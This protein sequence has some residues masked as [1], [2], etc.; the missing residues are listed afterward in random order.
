SGHGFGADALDGAVVD[1]VAQVSE[2]AHLAF[3][4]PFFVGQI[5]VEEH[6]DAGF[7]VKTGQGDEADPNGH[8]E[9]VVEK[10]EN[11]ERSNQ[12]ERHGHEN[13]GGLHQRTRVEINDEEDDEQGQ[14]HDNHQALLGA[15]HVFVFPAPKD[16]VAAGQMDR[17]F[18]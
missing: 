10:V 14:R 9:V 11:P 13:D 5:E 3:A 18:G 4:D 6:D 12:G 2:V 7:G 1:G 8:A 15:E 16:V 17:A